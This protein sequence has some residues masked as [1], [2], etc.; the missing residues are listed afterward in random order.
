MVRA[1]LIGWIGT[2]KLQI[3]ALLTRH[4]LG[5]R[6]DSEWA[7]RLYAIH[8]GGRAP[9]RPESGDGS[10]AG[11]PRPAIHDSSLRLPMGSIRSLTAY[12]STRRAGARIFGV[13]GGFFGGYRRTEI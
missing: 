1:S 11:T 2:P 10:D 7:Q 6:L 9:F 4:R 13:D 3:D 12:S 5:R 8:G